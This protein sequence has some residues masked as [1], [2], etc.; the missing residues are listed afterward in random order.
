MDKTYRVIFLGGAHHL[1]EITTTLNTIKFTPIVCFD[2]DEYVLLPKGVGN[3][4][5][6]FVY[7]HST[8]TDEEQNELIQ[9]IEIPMKNK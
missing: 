2:D 9:L 3:S 6:Y 7:V 4:P 8:L 1:E 5:R